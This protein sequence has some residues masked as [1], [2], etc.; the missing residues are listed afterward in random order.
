MDPPCLSSAHPAEFVFF[1]CLVGEVVASEIAVQLC[2]PTPCHH[3]HT[4]LDHLDCVSQKK[5]NQITKCQGRDPRTQRR[6]QGVGPKKTKHSNKGRV[7]SSN[8]AR[9][10]PQE[11]KEAREQSSSGR[12]GLEAAKKVRWH[13]P[14]SWQSQQ[15]GAEYQGSSGRVGLDTA[16]EEQGNESE[17]VKAQHT[18][19]SSEQLGLEAVEKARGPGLNS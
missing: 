13:R 19:Q 5:K 15:K 7:V 8:R 14:E 18:S 6:K 3:L 12:V 1:F 11:K 9:I 16:V 4:I 17:S 2:I 10:T